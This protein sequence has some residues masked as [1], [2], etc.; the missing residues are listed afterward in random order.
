MKVW[1]LD[2]PALVVDLDRLERNLRRMADRCREA[3]VRLRP[4][5]KAHKTPELARLQ[6]DYGASGLSVAKVGE[7]EVMAAAGFDDL[8]IV[9][10]VLGEAKYQRL[11]EV[12]DRAQVRIGLDSLD[13]ARAASDF[14]AARRRTLNVMLEVD[15]GF[16]RCGVQSLDEAIALADAIGE[17][18]GVELVGVMGF[19]GQA[20]RARDEYEVVAAGQREGLET[21]EVA[22]ALRA[23]GHSGVRDVSVG[24]SPSSPHA[25]QVYGV[26]EVRPGVYVFNDCKQVSLGAAT[27]EDCALTVLSTVV[28][29]PRAD[30]LV[31]D[32]GLKALSGEEY[33]WGTYGRLLDGDGTIV[34]WAAE[35]HG[36]ITIG[37]HNPDPHARIGDKVRIIPNHGCGAVNMHEVLYAVRGECVEAAWPVAA[38]GK[39]Q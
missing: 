36:V 3:G 20:Y 37:P 16:G 8:F 11:L 30:R 32:A 17:L 33:G 9:F 4:H 18:P 26:T 28:S 25:M 29:H 35:E 23:R 12:M 1:D 27:F 21:A 7:A 34:S 2:T 31:V 19:G 14:F 6:V 22:E 39:L 13:V 10:P 5:T 38:R 24:S 15:N